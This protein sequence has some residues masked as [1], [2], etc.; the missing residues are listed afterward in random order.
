MV[1]EFLKNYWFLTT[2]L[3]MILI[4]LGIFVWNIW[5]ECRLD[6]K[7]ESIRNTIHTGCSDPK[8][9]SNGGICIPEQPFVAVVRNADGNTELVWGKE[10]I[11]KLLQSPAQSSLPDKQ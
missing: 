5:V 10:N 7:I 3:C 9:F 1:K 6:A 8:Q 4:L 2:L 11:N